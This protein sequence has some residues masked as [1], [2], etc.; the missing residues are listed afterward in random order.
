MYTL[1]QGHVNKRGVHIIW[2]HGCFIQLCPYSFDCPTNL[3][4][5][6]NHAILKKIKAIK[7][8]KGG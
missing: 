5:D 8:N 1:C 6:K 7:R 2:N 4:F 3:T